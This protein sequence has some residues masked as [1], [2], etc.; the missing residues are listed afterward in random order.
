M[1]KG[2]S[3]KDLGEKIKQARRK[4]GMT[5]LQ[6][7]IKTEITQSSLSDYERGIKCPSLLTAKKLEEVLG[8]EL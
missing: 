2:N 1:D 6:L 8:I 5:Q 4:K 3:L 7:S